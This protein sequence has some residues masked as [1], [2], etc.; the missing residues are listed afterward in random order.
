MNNQEISVIAK[1]KVKNGVVEDV[2]EKLTELQMA[3]RKEAGC[4]FYQLHQ[5]LDNETVFILYESW[6]DKSH[7]DNHF[8][9]PHFKKWI[10][11]ES[12]FLSGPADINILKK[13]N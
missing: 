4:N 7:L 11:D 5:S 3:T 2:K 8:Q 13:I 6:Q 10:E 12:K 9:S 1:M